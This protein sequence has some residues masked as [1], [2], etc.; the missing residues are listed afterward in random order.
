MKHL[1]IYDCKTQKTEL[2]DWREI[3]NFIVSVLFIFTAIF[4]HFKSS[5]PFTLKNCII[6]WV[7]ILIGWAI[8]FILDNHKKMDDEHKKCL[9][10]FGEM[11]NSI[12]KN[13]IEKDCLDET[14][15]NIR[16]F[17]NS[18]LEKR[19]FFKDEIGAIAS[20]ITT[21]LSSAIFIKV[22]GL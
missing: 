20:F 17:H 19:K 9:E 16:D 15:K 2:I 7:M 10:V 1:A 13:R 12:E 22:F 8:N 6:V 4:C 18:V 5:E 14:F 3:R 21:I 11:E